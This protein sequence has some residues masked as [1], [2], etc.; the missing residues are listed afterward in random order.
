MVSIGGV[1][2]LGAVVVNPGLQTPE[3]DIGK[4]LLSP[5]VGKD[6][7][8]SLLRLFAGLGVIQ[9]LKLYHIC[10]GKYNKNTISNNKSVK[11][12]FL[13]KENKLIKLKDKGDSSDLTT[14]SVDNEKH[15]LVTTSKNLNVTQVGKLDID[16]I[17]TNFTQYEDG[18]TMSL[19]VCIRSSSD[20]QK[21][22][23]RIEDTNKELKTIL[24][25]EDTIILD[26]NEAYKLQS[27]LSKTKNNKNKNN[28][29]KHF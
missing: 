23:Q 14:L 10:N 25:K 15:L 13:T 22:K 7:Q 9:K 19:C 3:K 28:S 4:W 1:L 20:F 21:M 29:K 26:W 18:F 5:W 24:D 2:C 17:L 11:D 12:V 6:K 8:E 27:K 16:K